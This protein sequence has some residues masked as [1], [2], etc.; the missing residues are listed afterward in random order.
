MSGDTDLEAAASQLDLAGDLRIVRHV[1]RQAGAAPQHSIVLVEGFRRRPIRIRR[2]TDLDFG[3]GNQRPDAL[4][5]Q[6]PRLGRTAADQL[7]P[8]LAGVG[9][10][11]EQAHHVL[12]TARAAATETPR[13][14][15]I[16]EA[17]FNSSSVMEAFQP[18]EVGAGV[19]SIIRAP[20]EED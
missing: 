2:K 11:H 19:R 6:G 18:L 4:G 16:S 1:D 12:Q 7:R 15:F 8:A 5:I 10:E 20:A 14:L 13:A 9:I 3:R 17:N